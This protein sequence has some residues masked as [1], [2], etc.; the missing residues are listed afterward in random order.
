MYEWLLLFHVTGA[1][2]F[3]AGLTLAAAG[4]LAALRHERPSEV[5]LLLGLARRGV[6]LVAVGTAV[7]LGFGVWLVEEGNWGWDGWV[8]WA[9]A[10]V[11]VSTVLG[12]L[13]GRGP[14]RA[15][16]LAERL[17]REGD[18]PSD[19]LRRLLRDPASAWLN[20]GAAAAAVVVLALMVLKPEL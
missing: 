17:A 10:L 7:L 9:L 11:G 2:L 3:F 4:L 13:G 15:R 20:A 16:V 12:A 1:I 5:A 18:E 14:R 6:V 19:E 8:A